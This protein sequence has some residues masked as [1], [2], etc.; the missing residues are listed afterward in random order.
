MED[1]LSLIFKNY[2]L[3]D[4]DVYHL[5][6]TCKYFNSFMNKLFY[7]VIIFQFHHVIDKTYYCYI[8]K[9][10]NVKYVDNLQHLLTHLILSVDFN[11]NINNLPSSLIYLKFG[12]KFNQNVNN[13]PDKNY[14]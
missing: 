6:T 8:K 13:L 1:M 2:D 4:R 7:Q 10:I 11:Q 5:L 9:L 3:K 12:N 14:N